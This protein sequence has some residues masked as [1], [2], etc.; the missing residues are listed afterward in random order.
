MGAAA[1]GVRLMFLVVGPTAGMAVMGGT[2]CS[3]VIPR[4]VIL[5]R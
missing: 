3:S 1:F 4:G 2:W 5:G